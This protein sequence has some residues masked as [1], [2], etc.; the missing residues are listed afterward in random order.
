MWWRHNLWLVNK[1]ALRQKSGEI[2]AS[3]QS[4]LKIQEATSEK[5][6]LPSDPGFIFWRLPVVHLPLLSPHT[7]NTKV[8]LSLQ[9][10]KQS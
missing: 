3:N 9:A 7:L 6:G 5:W 4:T 2:K 8:A 10:Q 1:H